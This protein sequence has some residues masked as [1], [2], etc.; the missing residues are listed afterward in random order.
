MTDNTDDTPTVQH[1]VE[2]TAD[3]EL[4]AQ[5]TDSTLEHFGADV[6]TDERESKI[7]EPAASEFGVDDRPDESAAIDDAGEQ[8]RL[9]AS[10]DECQE[11]LS[12]E[13]AINSSRFDE[14]GE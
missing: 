3:G 12:G 10:T 1:Q 6:E 8:S 5:D 2:F 7:D 11:T 9:F 13:K 4:E 14:N